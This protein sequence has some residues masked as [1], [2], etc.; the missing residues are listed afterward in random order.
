M[1]PYLWAVQGRRARHPKMKGN[2][3]R[4]SCWGCT[5]NRR[6]PALGLLLFLNTREQTSSFL[7]CF[8]QSPGLFAVEQPP[9]SSFLPSR[10]ISGVFRQ[11]RIELIT[12]LV[13]WKMMNC[14][15]GVDALRENKADGPSSSGVSVGLYPLLARPCCA[16]A[17]P[18]L[19]HFPPT[20]GKAQRGNPQAQE[21]YPNATGNQTLISQGGRSAFPMQGTGFHKDMHVFPLG[22]HAASVVILGLAD[23]VGRMTGV[24]CPKDAQCCCSA[25]VC[26][27][28]FMAILGQLRWRWAW[29]MASSA[30][31]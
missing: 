3:G 7:P 30:S 20:L 6:A 18:A 13:D 4:S 22:F 26:P 24:C 17:P 9:K 29:L 27:F 5:H 16:G 25:K 28:W 2:G 31:P 12:Q 21:D 15:T 8:P 10:H 14:L 19:P 1:V 11:S 23:L